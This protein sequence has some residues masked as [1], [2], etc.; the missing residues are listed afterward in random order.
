M[1]AGSVPVRLAVIF[2][3]VL[4][5]LSGCRL[6]PP[7]PPQSARA[8]YLPVSQ[9][10]VF[11]I[12][13]DE[14]SLPAMRAT[15]ALVEGT[16]RP[17]ERVVIL[18]ARGGAVLVSAFA[19]P[20]PSGQVP[21]PPASLA[22]HPTS[23]QKARHA[24]AVQHYQGEVFRARQAL[25]RQERANLATWARSVAARVDAQAVPRVSH[26]V[27]MTADLSAAATD[28]ASMREAG[29]G[30]IAGAVIAIIG[31]SQAAAQLTPTTLADLQGTTVVVG[32]FPGTI[33]EQAAWQ[34]SLL[35]AGAARAVILAPATD[36]QLASV[37][38]QSLD[39]AVTDTLT[40]VLFGLDQYQ[41][42]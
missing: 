39:G 41:L 36:D 19:P 10:S 35:Q 9:P 16:T 14:D 30:Y 7:R 26:E 32:N 6:D 15:G 40:S 22:R 27:N 28:L 23:F 42:H 12:I 13:A 5:A 24:Q 31:V 8:L 11:M 34:A 25:Q 29:T 33:S 3:A 4:L 18:S 17:G 20:P 1:T 21:A 37:V 38:E 2:G